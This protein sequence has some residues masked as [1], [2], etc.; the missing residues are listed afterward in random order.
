MDALNER[1]LIARNMKSTVEL[2]RISAGGEGK[3]PHCGVRQGHGSADADRLLW[4]MTLVVQTSAP[5]TEGH[6][7]ERCDERFLRRFEGREA[8]IIS[9]RRR[10]AG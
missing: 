6:G 3:L 2:H 1:L 7:A 8:M 4:R 5:Q 10:S 9:L